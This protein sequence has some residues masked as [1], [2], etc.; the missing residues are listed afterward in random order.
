M[1]TPKQPKETKPP[2]IES[3]RD[4]ARRLA[5]EWDCSEIVTRFNKDGYTV[6]VGPSVGSA[7]LERDA[8]M[9]AIV[10]AEAEQRRSVTNGREAADLLAL[11]LAGLVS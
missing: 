7:P 1:S 10:R 6:H 8:L 11:E 3:L 9:K 5:L 4:R 2:S